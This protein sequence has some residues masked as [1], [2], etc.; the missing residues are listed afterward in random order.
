M[1]HKTIPLLYIIIKINSF[2]RIILVNK[3]MRH[4]LFIFYLCDRNERLQNYEKS[5]KQKKSKINIIIIN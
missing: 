2:T 5:N 1:Y 4:I 3:Y